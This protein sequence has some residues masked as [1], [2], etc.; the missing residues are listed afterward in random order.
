VQ[1]FAAEGGEDFELLVALSP[2]FDSAAVL[3]FEEACGIALTRIGTVARGRGVRAELA[4]RR[5]ELRGYD[6]FR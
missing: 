1:Q 5:L 4:G 2:D 6:H 3:E